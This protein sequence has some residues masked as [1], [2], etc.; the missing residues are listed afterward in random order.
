M[1]QFLSQNLSQRMSMEQ[2]LT[3]QLIQSMAILQKPVADLE[4]HIAEALESNAALE[5][6]EP[7]PE[8]AAHGP[9]S[10]DLDRNGSETV[11]AFARLD[12]FARD[13]NLDQEERIRHLHHPKHAAGERDAVD[14]PPSCQPHVAVPS[15]LRQASSKA[16]RRRPNE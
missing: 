1:S 14:E 10:G 5:L 9:P 7:E 12:R 16:R 2:R 11:D 3:P 6:A 4:A 15:L 13:Q 8:E